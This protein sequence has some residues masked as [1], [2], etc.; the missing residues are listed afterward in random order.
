MTKYDQG[1]NK[2]QFTLEALDKV[3]KIEFN[4]PFRHEIKVVGGGMVE[5]YRIG[6]NE[7]IVWEGEK[8]RVTK[9]FIKDWSY[10]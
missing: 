8:W 10:R 9:H 1:L 5:A 7:Y 2:V 4:V 6:I 3:K